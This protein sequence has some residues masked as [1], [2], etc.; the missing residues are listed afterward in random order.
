M[1]TRLVR[2]GIVAFMLFSH[3]ANSQVARWPLNNNANDVAGSIN[4]TLTNSPV[5]ATDNKEGSHALVLNG[6]NQYVDFGNASGLPVGTTARTI[7]AWT[8]SQSVSSGS[9]YIASYGTATAGKSMS[10]GQSGTTL[11]AGAYNDE[12]SYATFWAVGV[13][14]HICLTYDGTTARLYADGIEVA[15]GAKTWNLALSRAYIGRS[16]N[17]NFYWNGTVDDVRIYSSALSP[18]QV[19]ALATLPTAPAGLAATAVSSVS[20]NL[21]WTDASANETGFQIERSLTSGS[22]YALI[23]ATASNAVTYVDNGLTPQT[24]YY[25]RIRAINADGNSVYTTT[26]NSTTLAPG[27]IAPSGFAAN[28]LSSSSVN[29]TW[30]DASTDE[31]GFQIER[32]LTSGTNFSLITTTAANAV[33]YSDTG[34]TPSTR[35]YYRIRSANSNGNSPYIAEVNVT[36]PAATPIAPTGLSAT[37]VSTS[38]INLSWTDLSN[39]E[40]GFQVERSTTSGSGFVLVTTTAANSTSY[41]NTGLAAGT[42]YYFRIRSANVE[43]SSTYTLEVSATT[44]QLSPPIAPTELTAAAASPTSIILNWN[45]A[46]DNEAGFEV[47]RSLIAGSGFALVST[48]QPNAASYTDTNLSPVTTYYYRIRAKNTGG[49]SAYTT[50]ISAVTPEAPPLAPSL[51]ASAA[52]SSS[53]VLS[54]KDN[55]SNEVEFLIERSLTSTTGFTLLGSAPSNSISY[56]DPAVIAGTIYYYRIRAANAGGNSSYTAEV[57]TTLP[58]PGITQLCN[59]LFCDVNGGVGVGTQIIPTGYRMSV[60]GKVMAEGVKVDL[61]S[62]WPDYVFESSYKLPEIA[63]LKKYINVNKH[64]PN[65][66]SA[67]EVEKEGMDVADINTKLLEKIEELT[68]YLIQMEERVKQVEIE[69]QRLKEKKAKK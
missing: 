68:L 43:G 6:S 44:V 30:T 59:G 34:L 2:L 66:P 23:G 1:K 47:E 51:L 27:P 16:V 49:N 42:T 67:E 64:L 57:N 3:W 41:S 46:S 45:D 14:H 5:F 48:T 19:L 55:S 32:S 63:A 58:I 7:S 54:W 12:L 24:T 20:V 31:T 53:I 10:I 60:K 52:S 9:R 26:V 21:N 15:S 69:N 13:W 50:V 11:V 22:G 37:A 18:S 17:N 4:G 36:T 35:Y 38:T 28:A 33:N 25:Y 65:M 61:Q 56:S 29:L 39:N 62:A 40:T 8:K